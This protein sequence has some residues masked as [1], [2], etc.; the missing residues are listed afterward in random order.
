MGNLGSLANMLKKIRTPAKISSD[1]EDLESAEKIILPGVGSF[2]HGMQMLQELNF[3]EP[4]NK[5]VIREGTPI[6]GICLGMQLFSKTSEEGILAGLGWINADTVKFR[7]VDNP[8][9]KIPHMGW[10]T[11]NVSKPHFI[12]RDMDTKSMFYFVHSYHLVCKNREDVLSTSCYG[13]EFVS[14]VSKN[15]IVGVQFHPEKSHKYGMKILE[16]FCNF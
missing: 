3:I 12:Y 13:Y 10:D 2:D 7:T 16:N 6:L 9:L 4:L 5:K 8:S 15:N 14:S 11:L 1:I